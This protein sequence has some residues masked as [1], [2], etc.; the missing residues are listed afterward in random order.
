[1]KVYGGMDIYIHVFLISALAEDEWSASRPCR[2]TPGK[3]SP[4]PVGEKLGGTQSRSG[5]RGVE[6][7]FNPNPTGTRTLIPRSSSP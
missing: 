5:R 3:E 7:I 2:F 4:V 1:M 6:K